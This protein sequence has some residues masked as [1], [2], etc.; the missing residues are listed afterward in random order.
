MILAIDI[1]NT[2]TVLGFFKEGKLVHSTRITTGT[3]FTVDELKIKFLNIF[4]YLEIKVENIEKV[5]IAN[6]VPNLANIYRNLSQDLFSLNCVFIGDLLE[7]LPV[8]IALANLEEVGEDRIANAIAVEKQFKKDVIIVDFGTAITFDVVTL[9]KGYEGG[10]IY[11]GVN[12]GINYLSNATARLP[13]VEL[14]ETKEIVGTNTVHAIE[15]GLFH[16]YLSMLEGLITKI[17]AQYENDF[18]V[19]ATGGVGEVFYKNSTLINEYDEDLTLKG[20]S[21]LNDK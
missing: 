4:K 9:K 7:S 8:K 2:N 20:L 12:L 14:V 11:P 17:K 6:V 18:F 19:I 13:K 21:Y 16:G 5:I 1:G 10:I 15:S 3:N